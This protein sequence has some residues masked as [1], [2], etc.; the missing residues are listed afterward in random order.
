MLSIEDLYA[1]YDGEVLHGVSLEVREG[2]F[3]CVIGANTAGKSTLLRSISRL[4]PRSRGRI[5]FGGADLMRLQPYEVPKLGIAH[6]PEGRH[7]F[8]DMTV[9]ENL[10]LGAYP[11]RRDPRHARRL[12]ECFALFPRLKERRNQ[13]AGT[14]SGGEQQMVALGRAMMLGMRMLILDEPSHGLAPIV[15]DQVH[16]ALVKIHE[17]GTSI[18]LVEQNTALALSVASRGYVLESGRVVLSDTS[19]AL[20]QNPK[21][22]EAYLGL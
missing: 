22:R 4:V 10:M 15:V 16:D 6:V 18:L 9:E 11:V 14:L 1:G 7:L 17:S 13:R 21:V 8:P 19:R 12:E 5:V 3:V 2:E 20:Q